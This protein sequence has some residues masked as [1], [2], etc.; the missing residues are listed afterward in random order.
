[1]TEQ[2]FEYQTFVRLHATDAAGVM[3]YSQLFILIH[4]AYESLLDSL[5][6]RLA[7]IIRE[8]PYLLP[9][10]HA[11]ADYSLPAMVGD[12]LIINIKSIS[13][14]EKS[15]AVLFEIVNNDGEIV[16]TAKTVHASIDKTSRKTIPLPQDITDSFAK[17]AS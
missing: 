3:Y 15:Y 4:E 1:M 17:F 8:K 9:I 11:E 10:V 14:N 16:A 5:D 7:D 12:K 6:L 2:T 13:L